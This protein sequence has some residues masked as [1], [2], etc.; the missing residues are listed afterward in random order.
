[1]TKIIGNILGQKNSTV[2]LTDLSK[3][4][5]IFLKYILYLKTGGEKKKPNKQNGLG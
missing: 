1:L 2:N 5:E 4:L 3:F